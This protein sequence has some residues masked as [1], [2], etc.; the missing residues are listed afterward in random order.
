MSVHG[1]DRGTHTADGGRTGR[2]REE[3]D[4]AVDAHA[5]AAGRREAVLERV[6]E[7][8]VD[9]LRL[10]VALRLLP[11]LL[12]EARALLERV[13]Q[14]RVR[15]AD[16]LPAEEALEALAQA[17]PAPVPLGERGHHLRVPDC[18]HEYEREWA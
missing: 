8:L 4:E 15:V 17:R 2:V 13:V 1:K 3:H 18:A 12:L 5:P 9:V 10:V 11:D 6:D 16:L 14:L 7:R